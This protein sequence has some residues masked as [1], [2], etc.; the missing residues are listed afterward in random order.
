MSRALLRSGR[1]TKIV[2]AT[3]HQGDLRYGATAGIQCSC[4][5]LMS[6]CWSTFISVT[7][8]DGTDLDMILENGDRLFKSLN[9]YRLLGVDDL[10]RSVDIYS[11]SV[12]IFLLDNKTGEITL[13]AYLVSLKEI[14]ESCLNIGS[15]ALL[16]INGIF[17]EFFREKT[18]FTYLILIVRMMKVIYFKMALLF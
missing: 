9:Q 1:A 7:M 2:Q 10:P 5:S 13:N 12:D 18:V 14:I 16:I 15:G 6:V 4:M 11:H 8:W 17:L 3:H